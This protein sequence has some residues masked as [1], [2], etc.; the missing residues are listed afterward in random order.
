MGKKKKTDVIEAPAIQE[1][2]NMDKDAVIP[3]PEKES[4]PVLMQPEKPKKVN[5]VVNKEKVVSP[6]KKEIKE[7]VEEKKPL[8]S[9]TVFCQIA[10]PRWDQLA[11]FKQY[12]KA[13]NLGPFTVLEWRKELE[14]FRN[15]PIK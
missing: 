13:N 14:K 4:D 6:L 2:N 9:L 15:K 5:E 12:A 8:I 3:M 11:G 7:K 1:I 10:G